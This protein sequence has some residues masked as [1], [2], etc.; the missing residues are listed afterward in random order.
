MCREKLRSTVLA[1]FKLSIWYYYFFNIIYKKSLSNLLQHCFCFMFWL[2]DSKAYGIQIQT[3]N[4]TCTSFTDLQDLSSLTRDQT[5]AF[6]SES[7]DS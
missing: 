1:N 6:V 2:L 7:E 5:C 3:K 4:Q